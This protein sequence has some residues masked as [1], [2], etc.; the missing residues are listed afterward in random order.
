M[1]TDQSAPQRPILEARDVVKVFGRRHNR[2]AVAGVSLSVTEGEALGIVG[3]SGSGK[4]T[5]AR[6]L[7]GFETASSGES[8]VRGESIPKLRGR[9]RREFRRLVQMVFQNPYASLN[10]FRSIRATLADGYRVIGV[11]GAERERR[12]RELLDQVGLHEGVLDR[13][14]HE[15]SGGQRQRIVL[16]RALTVDPS[17]IVAD[18]PLSALDV[19]IQAQVLN[20]LG[21]LK[22]S[23]GLTIVMVTHDLR[24]VN[25]FCDRIAVMYMGAL[26][27]LGSRAEI[28]NR[29]WHPYTRMLIGAA[30]VDTPG[31]VPER[32]WM[33]STPAPVDDTSV[34]CPF[35][36]RCWLREQ[37]GNPERCVTE[38]PSFREVSAETPPAAGAH[39]SACHFAED[40]E[41]AASGIPVTA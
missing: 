16:A 28:M 7:M 40:V 33:H 32:P 14:P 24:V 34:G 31:V 23:L 36:A 35:A 10:P 37:L 9:R 17:V 8:R 18:E 39:A 1:N 38:R 25:F 13:Y 12:M 4:T 6:I 15:F 5:L 30:P 26:V 29:S 19:S 27:E 41:R 21:D 3:E 20:L 11:K 22:R 2:P